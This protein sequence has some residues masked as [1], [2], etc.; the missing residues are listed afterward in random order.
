MDRKLKHSKSLSLY[1]NNDETL[2]TTDQN[3]SKNE[4]FKNQQKT[5]NISFIQPCRFSLS[6][7]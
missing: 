2:K 3:R 7:L 5:L 4:Q 6:L 1:Y